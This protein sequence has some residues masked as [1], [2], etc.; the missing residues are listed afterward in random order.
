[1]GKGGSIALRGC[2]GYV[3][4]NLNLII[5][6]IDL[7]RVS[8]MYYGDSAEPHQGDSLSAVYRPRCTLC[9]VS[10]DRPQSSC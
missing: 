9:P 10:A 3:I 6:V 4:L 5:V 8:H 2:L 7:N 1:M